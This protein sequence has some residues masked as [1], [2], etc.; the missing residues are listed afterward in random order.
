MC[1]YKEVWN[2]NLDSNLPNKNSQLLQATNDSVL[3][4]MEDAS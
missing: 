3:D 4:F 1:L 2:W